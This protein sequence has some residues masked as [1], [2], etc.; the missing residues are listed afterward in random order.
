LESFKVWKEV[1]SSSIVE[2]FLFA[3]LDKSV[4]HS[5]TEGLI[6]VVQPT[7]GDHKNAIKYNG[8]LEASSII[9]FLLEY[10]FPVVMELT[11]DSWNRASSHPTHKNLLALFINTPVPAFY[12]DIGTN[13]RG[14]VVCT[15]SANTQ[16]L[17]RWG[18]SGAVIPTATFLA[19]QDDKP[20]LTV[21]NEEDETELNA[22]SLTRFIEG[23]LAGTYKSNLKS[24]PIPEQHAD[25]AVKILVG[26]TIEAAISDKT[27]EV[28]FVEF[29][30]PWCGHCKKLS[31]IWEELAESFRGDDK[32]V[33][34]KLDATANSVDERK[35]AL[36]GYPTMYAFVNGGEKIELY[37]GQHN[38]ESLKAFVDGL[39]KTKEDL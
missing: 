16:I 39:R 1:A 3:H 7:P 24:E 6:E 11:Q 9:A 36:E 25:D 10:G 5:G 30:A 31:P 8:Q 38:F 28:V 15:S 33:I 12:Y 27:K 2:S 18:G 29:Y 22:E 32:V 34:A 14:K 13:Y 4:W 37:Q 26:K 19:W 23:A 21:W 20:R 17:T 35:I